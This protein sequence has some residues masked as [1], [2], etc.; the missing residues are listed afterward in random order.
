MRAGRGILF[1]G[2]DRHDVRMI[3][4]RDGPRLTAESIDANRVA[5]KVRRQQLQRHMAPE[6]GI[7]RSIHLAHASLAQLRSDFVVVQAG[8]RG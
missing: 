3:Q 4:R 6:G 8:A 1:D 7:E 2:I 5:R